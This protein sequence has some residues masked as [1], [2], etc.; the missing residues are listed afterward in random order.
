MSVAR[1]ELEAAQ[2]RLKELEARMI[3]DLQLQ[4]LADQLDREAD[5]WEQQLDKGEKRRLREDETSPA[6]R[7]MAFGFTLLAVTPVVAMIGISLSRMMRHE[8]E[9]AWVL[10]LLG[11]AVVVITS[12]PIA[13]RAIAHRA[14]AAWKLSRQARVEAAALRAML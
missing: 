5:T 13:R 11:V 4:L 8:F 7:V 9:W 1:A 12:L 2:A 14:S 10:L 6:S 3:S